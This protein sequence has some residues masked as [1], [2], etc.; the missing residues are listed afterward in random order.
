MS[1][2]SEQLI[3]AWTNPHGERSPF[4]TA[5]PDG[6]DTSLFSGFK[7]AP[8]DLGTAFGL[9]NNHLKVGPYANLTLNLGQATPRTYGPAGLRLADTAANGTVLGQLATMLGGAGHISDAEHGWTAPINAGGKM[10]NNF[11]RSSAMRSLKNRQQ[12]IGGGME[13]GGWVGGYDYDNE[14][15]ITN[16]D[17]VGS[18]NYS[19]A[20]HE[21]A[22][23]A[24]DEIYRSKITLAFVDGVQ[25]TKTTVYDGVLLGENTKEL[26]DAAMVERA[27]GI[28]KANI[29]TAAIVDEAHAAPSGGITTGLRKIFDF[30]E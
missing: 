4:S 18:T 13:S 3:G 2:I 26:W 24:Y 15:K 8:A 28:W 10:K 9:E 27:V 22:Q 11:E 17:T 21:N 12:G 5:V 14:Y 6:V 20:D 1:I 29:A 30:S 19:T 25:E 7:Y 16:W 23:S